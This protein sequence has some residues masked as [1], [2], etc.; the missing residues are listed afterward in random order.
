MS[1]DI[2][3][4]AEGY[5]RLYRLY[6]ELQKELNVLDEQGHELGRQMQQAIDHEKIKKIFSFITKKDD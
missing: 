5:E 6:L 2:N 3:D 4:N 1:Q